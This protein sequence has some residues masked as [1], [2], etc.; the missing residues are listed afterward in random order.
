MIAPEP[1]RRVE[2]VEALAQPAEPP[3]IGP[4][5]AG[6]RLVIGAAGVA[7]PRTDVVAERD[8]ASVDRREGL[9][10]LVLGALPA[11]AQPEGDQQN[12]E[13]PPH[14]S[15]AYS[16][17]LQAVLDEFLSSYDVNE[18]HTVSTSA[19]PQAVM[20]AIHHVTPAEVPLL[21]VLMGIRSLPALLRRQRRHVRRPLLD[22]FRRSGFVTLRQTRD[23][24]V[25][26]GVGRFWQPAGGLRK[27]APADFRDFA[28]PGYAKAAFNFR[29]E[30]LDGRTVV[31]TE[32]RVAT[33]DQRARRTFTRYWRVIHPGS[34]LIRVAWLRAIRRRA[35]RDAADL[36]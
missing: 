9:L 16:A 3:R 7:E 22:G 30:R 34:A 28:E 13:Q 32:T 29:V 8:Q 6:E 35:E 5:L 24:L 2:P 20:D 25:M 4:E 26:G 33:T 1:A 21:V 11:G 23:E 14:G 27:I 19:T 10:V 12:A 36:R 15:P 17:K 31:T 18:V